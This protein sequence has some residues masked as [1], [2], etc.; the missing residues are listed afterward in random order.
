MEYREDETLVQGEEVKAEIEYVLAG[1]HS[2]VYVE[3]KLVGDPME[4]A[5]L[6]GINWSFTKGTYTLYHPLLLT[7]LTGDVAVSKTGKRQVRIIHRYHFS[8]ALKR[9][10][11]IIALQHEQNSIYATAKGA[12]EKIKQFL[13]PN[14]VLGYSSYCCGL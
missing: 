5:S 4:T 13:N 8:S 1:C 14:H 9:M 6:A 7:R 2:L 3:G 11:T 12:P 10:S